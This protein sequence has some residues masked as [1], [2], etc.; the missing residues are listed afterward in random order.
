MPVT[1][2]GISLP[3]TRAIQFLRNK[4]RIPT[5]RWDDFLGDIHSK[6]FAIAGAVKIDLL[7]D[8]HDAL[9]EALESGE[10]ISAFRRRFDDIVK[11]HGWS[12]KGERGWRTRVIYDNNLRSAKMAGRWAQMQ[13]TK[14]RR[15]YLQ[16]LTVGDDKVRPQ[17]RAWDR[18]ILPIDDVF[19]DTGYPPND[20]GCRCTVRSLSH[21]D[22]LR[23]GMKISN[24]PEMHKSLR[25]NNR[26]GEVYGEVPD[27]IGVGWDYNVGKAWLSAESVFAEKI[28]NLPARMRDNIFMDC[29]EPFQYVQVGLPMPSNPK[30]FARWGNTLRYSAAVGE[31]RPACYLSSTVLSNM[32]LHGVRPK[33]ALVVVDDVTLKSAVQRHNI[34]EGELTDV[35]T[36]L[37]H[38]QAV[39]LD[40][41][42]GTLL[43]SID[44]GE[45]RFSFH[46][47]ILGSNMSGKG[48]RSIYAHAIT[49]IDR[50][51][52]FN[53]KNATLYNLLKSGL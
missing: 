14:D 49:D 37:S 10:G 33:T 24:S 32:E 1:I 43:W 15:P 25:V 16:Y 42:A 27:G 40:K 45:R 5:E 13:E 53:T 50:G 34:T 17:H 39:Y 44:L 52:D 47:A 19:W 7:K 38:P 26:T 23:Q 6:G 2:E 46:A 31:Y 41:D 20:Y 4:L 48:Q 28:A 21:R 29:S 22:V 11:K 9:N 51:D 30:N 12:Y 18:M 3:S 36:A 8:F 35:L